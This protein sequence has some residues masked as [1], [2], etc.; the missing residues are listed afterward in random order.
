MTTTAVRIYGKKDLRLERFELPQIREDEILAHVVSD[1]LCMSSY[2]LAVQGEEHKRV[3]PGIDKHPVMIGH[4]FC[5]D[6]VEVGKKWKDRFK[7]GDKFVIQPALNYKG[8]LYAPGYSYAYIGGD[9]TYIII[10]SEVMEMDCLLPYKGEAYYFGSLTEPVSC[11][12]GAFRAA[13]H[14]NQGSYDHRMGIEPGGAMAIL[15]GCGPMGLGSI[16]LA[17]HGSKRPRLLIVTDI[18]EDRLNRARALFPPE[19]AK[20]DGVDLRFLNTSTMKDPVAELKQIAG[21]EG[22]DDVFVMAAVRP[23]VEQADRLL[24]KGGCL[25]FFAGPT[26]P[27]FS[28]LMNFYEVHYSG[29]HLVGTSGGNTEDMRIALDLMARGDIDPSLMITHVGG[30]NAVVETTLNLPNIPG[31]K[32]LIYTNIELPLTALQ[33]FGRL[34]E[35]D[36]LFAE[37]DRLVKKHHGLWNGEAEEYLLKHAQ[38]IREV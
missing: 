27:G 15:A 37:L 23:L 24:G 4:E 5:G 35:T 1:S 7:P 36:P 6:I 2:K 20:K 22:F 16:D 29:H 31:G 9:A 26:D 33:D 11:I 17:L 13:Y 30:L 3:P 32:K 21:G 28:A 25:N 12:V 34:G 10:P 8:S 14:F 19:Q 38:P 18:D